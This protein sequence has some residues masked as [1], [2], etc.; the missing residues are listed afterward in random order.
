MATQLQS[1]SRL[2]PAIESLLAGLR[3][4]IRA[5]VWADGLAAVFLLLGTAFWAS[6]ALDWLV[7]PPRPLRLVLLVGLVIGLGYVVYR[8]LLSR[9]FVPLLDRNM[10]VLLER[11]F[12]QFG[13]SLLTSVELSERPDHAVDF[14]PE[15]L[16]RAHRQALA[17]AERV[18][19]TQVFNTAPLARRVTLAIALMASVAVFAVAAPS[20]LGTWARRSLFLSSELWPRRTHLSVAGFD[21]SPRVKIARG[22]DWDLVVRA[23]AALGR[24]VPELVE[25]RYSTVEGVRGRENMSRDGVVTPGEAQFQPYNYAFKSVLAPLEFY[26]VGGDDREGPYYLDVVDSPTISGMTLRCE[27]PA[28]TARA[29]RDL[30]VAGLMQV[31]RGTLITILATANKPLVDVQIDDVADENAPVTHRVDVAQQAGGTPQDKF[32]FKVGRLDGDKTLLFTLRDLDGIRSREAVRLTLSAVSDEPP[33]VNVLLKGVGAAITP[34]ARLPVE[35]EVTD[36]YGVTK[37]WFDFHVDDAAPQQRPLEAQAS[38]QGQL[39]VSGVMELGDLKL[40]PKQRLHWAVQAA[41]NSALEGGPNVGTSQRYALDVV[42]PEQLRS[43]LEARELTLRRRFETMIEELADTRDLLAGIEVRPAP[44]PVDKP[45]EPTAATAPHPLSPAVQVERVFQ[46][47][48]RS[49]HEVAELGVSF[50][51]ICEELVNNRIDTVELKTRLQD[52]ISLPLKAIAAE[53][54]PPLLEKLKGLSGQLGD[55]PTAVATQ[56]QT[57][58]QT[59]AILVEMRGVL[60]KML[61]L[62]TFNEALDMLRQII[63][64]QQ[65]VSDET[66][67]QQ[68]KDLRSL[69]E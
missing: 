46:N 58:A 36:D 34:E 49:M 1:N 43:I 18:N 52:G 48:E 47:S 40:V 38:G 33:Q 15:M 27:F 57:L 28:Y 29:A 56:A 64:S 42:T 23:D 30:P 39:P 26:V 60:D 8:W 25:V 62:E 41:D 53:R 68:K 66:K 11:R 21:K 45:T 37:T 19:L 51:E 20:A 16:A 44:A 3:R 31:P 69:I 5:Y 12:G 7:E 65:K 50:E 32:Q 24:D 6:L 61:E 14:N 22:S 63:D 2:E 59:D 9:L 13:D 10:A 4:R 17:G 35:G 55:P 67:E 54:F